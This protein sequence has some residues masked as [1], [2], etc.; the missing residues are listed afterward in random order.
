MSFEVNTIQF[1]YHISSCKMPRR[2]F[3]FGTFRCGLYYRG[4]FILRTAFDSKIKIEEN[5][6]MRE[7]KT[8]EYKLKI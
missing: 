2:L 7:F 1:L 3:N 8:V 5:E 6:I 4:A